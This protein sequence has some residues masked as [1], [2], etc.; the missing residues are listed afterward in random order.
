MGLRSENT[1]ENYKFWAR[2]IIGFA[3][4]NAI[5]II[6]IVVFLIWWIF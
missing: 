4:L 6:G 5:L 2:I 1:E 3:L